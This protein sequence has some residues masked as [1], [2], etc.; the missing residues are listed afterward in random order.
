MNFN[1]IEYTFGEKKIF[2]RR[3]EPNKENVLLFIDD[4]KTSIVKWK[5]GKMTIDSTY[6]FRINGVKINSKDVLVEGFIVACGNP[7]EYILSIR[8]EAI[9]D[10]LRFKK[11]VMK[12]TFNIN[13]KDIL[14]LKNKGK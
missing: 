7:T 11:E 12:N 2:I 4:A 10:A 5:S 14:K 1:K 8:T 6:D 9:L 3:I 13:F